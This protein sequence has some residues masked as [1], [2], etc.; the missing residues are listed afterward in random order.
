MSSAFDELEARWSTHLEVSSNASNPRAHI[1]SADFEAIVALGEPAIPLIIG[2]YRNGGSL[3]WGAALSR[4][5]GITRFGDGLVGDLE[6]T[7]DAWLAWY[8]DERVK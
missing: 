7:R 2:R 8:D 6:H 1:D 4:I 3:F 5:T